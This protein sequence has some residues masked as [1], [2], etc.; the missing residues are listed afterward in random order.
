VYD[1][2]KALGSLINSPSWEQN[3]QEFVYL[4]TANAE[5]NGFNRSIFY[6]KKEEITL[7]F[8]FLQNYL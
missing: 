5:H 4:I 2:E 7:L 6:L 3:E 1:K 8:R